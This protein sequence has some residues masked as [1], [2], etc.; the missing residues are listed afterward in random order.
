MKPV[1]RDALAL[2]APGERWQALV[3]ALLTLAAAAAEALGIGLV[4]PFIGLLANPDPIMADPR[5]RAVFEWSGARTVERFVLISAVA[6]IAVYLAKNLYLALLYVIQARFI[7]GLEARLATDLLAAYLCAPYT[8]RLARNSAEQ[9]RVITGEVGRATAGFMMPLL[10]LF[11]E[12]LAVLAIAVLLFWVQPVA[13]AVA[14]AL[15]GGVGYAIQGAFRRQL[16]LQ[17]EA[18]VQSNT[19]MF[20]W[21][22]QGLGAFKE[23]KVLG[24]E[25]YF[26]DAFEASSRTYARATGTFTAVNLMPRLAVE[27]VAVV[28]LL[29]IVV[30]ALATGRPTHDLVPLLTLFGLAAVRVMPSA[31]RMVGAANNLRFYAPA[32]RAVAADLR[33]AQKSAAAQPAPDAAQAGARERFTT[34]ELKSVQF[35]YPGA[36]ATALSDV[37][38]RVRS[39]EVVAIVGRSG[40]GKTTLGD[41][42]LG[43]LDPL[44]GTI[45]VNGQATGSLHTAW[46]GMS[47]LVPQDIFVLD[48]TVRRNV[49][50]GI[51]DTRIDDARVWAALNQARLEERVRTMPRGLD[52][53]VGE[54]G[55]LLSGG[56]RQRLGIARALYDDPDILVLDEAT[57]AL[58]PATEAEFVET[59]K[60]LRG[61]KTVIVITHRVASI[62]W[63]ERVLVMSSGRIVGSGAYSELAAGN[64]TFAELVRTADTGGSPER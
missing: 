25:E 14:V 59:L 4:F 35:S 11:T 36:T 61:R 51:S 10:A 22:S 6:L 17:R 7:C 13:T 28:V 60:S 57:S 21:A 43:L 48:D 37:N 33:L 8:A 26:V 16:S 20:R 12:G 40:S 38:L 19:N 45:R 46:P 9:I 32:L 62:A 29:G 24:R 53:P 15:I 39:G 27:L 18:R 41:L 3:L 30:V 5:M 1:V 34:L 49:A 42:V 23:A 31:T 54:R 63:C 55:A 44:E 50:F 2:L 56:E 64:A 58:D 52:T 47:G